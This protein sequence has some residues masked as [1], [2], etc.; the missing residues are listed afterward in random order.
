MSTAVL[1]DANFGVLTL[2]RPFAGFVDVYEGESVSTPILFTPRGAD[3]GGGGEALDPLAGSPG[4]REDLVAAYSVPLGSR[5]TLAIPLVTAVSGA[6]EPVGHLYYT[7]FVWWRYRSLADFRRAR[8]PWHLPRTDLGFSDELIIPGLEQSVVYSQAENLTSVRQIQDIKPAEDIRARGAVPVLNRPL[9][10]GGTRGS[11]QQGLPNLFAVSGR[12]RLLPGF[13]IYELQ[14]FAD[15]LIIGAYRQ[16]DIPT[17]DEEEEPRTVSRPNWNFNG[18]LG[19]PDSVFAQLFGGV[20]RVPTT[21]D[22]GVYVSVG[23]AP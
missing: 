19:A 9:I 22:A 10:P 23:S 7:W 15:E 14:A 8:I 3:T 5:V 17:S 16:E 6:E 18:A 21:P 13:M 11:V 1:A 4:Y 2:L 20:S 12:D